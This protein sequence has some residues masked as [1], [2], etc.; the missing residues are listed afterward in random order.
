MK[1][2]IREE[3]VSCLRNRWSQ[4]KNKLEI[5]GVS[6]LANIPS[7][8]LP[9]YCEWYVW[10]PGTIAIYGLAANYPRLL[11][12]I[13]GS[14]A[15]P[16]LQKERETFASAEFWAGIPAVIAASATFNIISNGGTNNYF[17]TIAGTYI[18]GRTLGLPSW[19]YRH[20]K[21]NI[22]LYEKTGWRTGSILRS[23]SLGF[24][25]DF[26]TIREGAA[27]EVM[28]NW[29]YARSIDWPLLILV[30][31]VLMADVLAL[32]YGGAEAFA[33]HGILKEIIMGMFC[34]FY[35]NHR[36][37]PGMAERIRNKLPV[38]EAQG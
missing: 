34:A 7:I 17:A 18:A 37:Y 36:F 11:K 2:K 4:Y 27:N 20:R 10:L 23:I 1:Q 32:G 3:R 22:E 28:E 12:R 35:F 8:L 19:V 9:V 16:Q 31:P 30:Y 24:K 5:V 29:G 33:K 26:S 14:N 15:D 21:G 13:L 25:R 6:L 38:E